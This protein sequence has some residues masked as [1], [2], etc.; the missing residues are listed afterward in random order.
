MGAKEIY[1]LITA[2]ALS[3]FLVLTPKASAETYHAYL[4]SR[5]E[6]KNIDPLIKIVKKAKKNDVVVVHLK[7]FGGDV[8][9]GFKFIH[10]LNN[11]P[12]SVVG[13]IEG[14]CA[15]MCATIS[16]YLDKVEAKPT[17]LV[18]FHYYTILGIPAIPGSGLDKLAPYLTEYFNAQFKNMK[19]AGLLTDVEY[20]K[21]MNGKD[22]F[23]T[24]AEYE[25]RLKKIN[26]S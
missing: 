6:T 15:S 13:K 22:V 18:M 7:S 4:Y 16:L 23:M 12:A 9:P 21:I 1:A 20:K 14:T 24:G 17:A 5:V 2:T 3:L 8:I 26:K 11:S 19:D 25:R 10:A